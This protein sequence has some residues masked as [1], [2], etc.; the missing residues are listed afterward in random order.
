MNGKV[1]ATWMQK[2]QD[3]FV[4]R[5]T[6]IDDDAKAAAAAV[7]ECEEEESETGTEVETEGAGAESVADLQGRDRSTSETGESRPNVSGESATEWSPEQRFEMM[8]ALQS[9]TGGG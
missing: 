7:D 3:E 8:G 6:S 1:L 4:K 9:E 5:M 2:L